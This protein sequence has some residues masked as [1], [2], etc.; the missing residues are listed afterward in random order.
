MIQWSP[1]KTCP[2]RPLRRRLYQAPSSIKRVLKRNNSTNAMT[3][4]HGCRGLPLSCAHIS[5]IPTTPGPSNEGC[6]E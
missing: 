6:V 1:K 2:R 5:G 4:P 3:N